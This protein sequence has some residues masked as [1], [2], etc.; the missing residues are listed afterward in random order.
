NS[1]KNIRKS[2][3]QNQDLYFTI[4]PLNG[5]LA[6]D[7]GLYVATCKSNNKMIYYAVMV[8]N[9]ADSLEDKTISI[10]NNCLSTPVQESR[11]D[12][13]PI[14]QNISIQSNGDINY[15]YAMWG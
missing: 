14:L 4:N 15:E 6:S 8:M 1:A 11:S 9:L 10:G 2:T 5:P 13:K 12:P 3:I 7:R